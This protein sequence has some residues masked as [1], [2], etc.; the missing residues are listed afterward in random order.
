MSFYVFLPI[1]APA[2]K[3][4][5]ALNFPDD[6]TLSQPSV[7]HRQLVTTVDIASATLPDGVRRQTRIALVARK[8][9]VKSSGK[10]LERCSSRRWKT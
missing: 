2:G 5:T 7:P 9:Q 10:L 1:G 3:K 8:P 4:M 6:N